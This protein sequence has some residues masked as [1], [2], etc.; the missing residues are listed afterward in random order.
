MSSSPELPRPLAGLLA[1]DLSSSVAGQ[2]TGRL[3]AMQGATVVLVEPP[4]G[5]PTRWTPP[6]PYLFRHLNQGKQSLVSTDDGVLGDLL[7]RADV[8]VRDQGADLAL[9]ETTV[10]CEVGDFPPDGPYAG[11]RGTE[12]VHQALS[13]VMNAT[14]SIDREPIYGLGHRS[15]YATGTTAY[16]SVVAALHERRRSGLGQ[17]VRASVFESTA[18]MGQNLVSQ[19][20]YNGTAETRAA[21]PGFLA[22]LRCADAWVVLFAIRN[23]PSLCRVFGMED[24]LE[25]PRMATSGDRLAHWPEV[26]ERMQERATDMLA[27][28]VVDGLQVGRVSAEKVT[29]LAELVRS[30]QWRV[31][32][33][34]TEVGRDDHREAALRRVFVVDGAFAE[35]SAP[36]PDRAVAR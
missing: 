28:E 21:Y 6:V 22:V 34:L 16:I 9:A 18:A 15:G 24:L 35:V 3:L 25:D 4:E 32:S 26:V 23:W 30:E 11:W 19:Y 14:G 33:M 20:S 7:G 27:D 2:Y 17:R 29:D 10:D 13:G 31:R 1:V 8:V 36:A 12:L 5:T